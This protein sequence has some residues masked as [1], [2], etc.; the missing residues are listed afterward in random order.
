MKTHAQ[1]IRE[2]LRLAHDYAGFD[3]PHHK[4]WLID[5]MVNALLGGGQEEECVEMMK[6]I[7]EYN[8]DGTYAEWDRGI[9]P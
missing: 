1:R 9:A 3:G 5:R 8:G 2:A 4:S 6:W 7:E